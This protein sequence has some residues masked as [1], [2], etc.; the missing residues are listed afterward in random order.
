MA[1]YRAAWDEAI[2]EYNGYGL[3]KSSTQHQVD[4]AASLLMFGFKVGGNLM[5]CAL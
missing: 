4:A 3:A 2:A 1:N 5:T